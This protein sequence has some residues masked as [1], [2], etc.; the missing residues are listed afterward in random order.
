VNTSISQVSESDYFGFARAYLDND[1]EVYGLPRRGPLYDSLFAYLVNPD[2]HDF[3]LDD[4]A[5]LT[6][7][8]LPGQGPMRML[9]LG[10]GPG[11][12][13]WKAL[14][15]GHDAFGID[16]NPRKIDLARLWASAMQ[17][18]CDWLQRV[19]VQNAGNLAYADET[20]DLVT[21]YHVVEHV[22]DLRSVL[23]EAV[24]VTKRGGWIELRAPDYRMSYDTHYCMPWPRFMPPLQAKRWVAAMGRPEA[25]V[26]TFYY[27]TGPEVVALLESLGCR[28]QALLY[29]EHRDGKIS[30]HQGN[31]VCDPIIFR[32]DADVSALAVELERLRAADALPDIYKTCLE[33]TIVAQRK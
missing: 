31:L 14:R 12:L 19:D 30:Q 15:R 17:Y 6:G 27:V 32:S 9:D 20:F 16:L 1:C 28:I 29:K 5:A 11:T 4:L 26:G 18:P 2:A 13:V 24:R 25:G 22:D 8:S 7:D 21:S 10:C 3:R 23:Y 33:F